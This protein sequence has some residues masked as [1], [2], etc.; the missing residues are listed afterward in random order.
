[1]TRSAAAFVC[2]AILACL[3]AVREGRAA[4]DAD[5]FAKFLSERE[6]D[7]E[8]RRVLEEPGPW[9]DARQKEVI[10]VLKRLAAPAALEVPWR[11][12]ATA[13][14]SP[15]A[16]EDRLVRVA[17]RATFV[18]VQRLTEEQ[19]VLA[20]RPAL[21]VV[22]IVTADGGTVDAVVP[23]AP[24]AW[25]RWRPID[26]PAF[27]VGLP[28]STVTAPV[29]GPPPA[30]AAA[31]PGDAATLLVAAT[32]IGF[33]PPTPLGRLGMDYGLFESVVDNAKLVPGDTAAFYAMLA[34]AGRAAP[35]VIEAAAG[36]PA[37]IL[38]IIDPAQEWFASHRGD[39]V[40]ITGVARRAVR[41]A[42]D[43]DWR[44]RQVGADHYW[45]LYVFVNTPLLAVNDRRQDDY[46]IVC[47]VRE[48]PAGFP[49]GDSIGERVTVSG[50][51]LKRYLYPLPDLDIASSQ[52]DRKT[53]GQ[54][55]ATPLLIGRTLAWTPEPS[56]AGATSTLSWIFTGLAAAVGLALV[57]GLWSMNRQGGRR[58][59]LPE[60][61]DLP[62]D[63][64]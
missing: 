60:R 19:A 14:A 8:R 4:G 22:R 37:D 64:R 57:Y 58:T 9:D 35:G 62:E 6:I 34:A 18:G 50:F 7:R 54:K 23:A 43:E 42:I 36:G 53:R 52:G 39:P 49:T 32:G 11:M 33:E 56:L 1:M 48:L 44:R 16:V 38:P 20:D 46:P 17:G 59:D 55:M 30:D 47:V 61:I 3:P 26:E 24:Q 63:R 51:A 45:E 15:A 10:R 29:P 5:G 31:W 28:L 2:L 13:P 41:I 40:T 12:G 25:S 27:L 21:D